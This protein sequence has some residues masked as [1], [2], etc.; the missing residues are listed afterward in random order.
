LL[1]DINYNINPKQRRKP[2]DDEY[3]SG[4]ELHLKF[5]KSLIKVISKFS[6]S[7]MNINNEIFTLLIN[8]LEKSYSHDLQMFELD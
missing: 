8:I 7:N 5:I 1:E 6:Q 2:I 3:N 4:K